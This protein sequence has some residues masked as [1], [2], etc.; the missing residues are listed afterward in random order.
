MAGEQGDVLHT[1]R[2]R[3]PA[4]RS[5]WRSSAKGEHSSMVEDAP[6][7]VKHGRRSHVMGTV[8]G[9]GSERSNCQRNSLSANSMS[10]TPY[11]RWSYGVGL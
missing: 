7:S 3:P 1:S 5:A 9:T 2:L 11:D 10:S 4:R 8:R 6:T